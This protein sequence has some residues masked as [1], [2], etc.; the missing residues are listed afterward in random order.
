MKKFQLSKDFVFEAITDHFPTDFKITSLA[1][2]ARL[3]YY[4]AKKKNIQDS[5][6]FMLGSMGQELSMGLGVALGVEHGNKKC[7]VISSDGS[8]ISSIGTL[9][10]IGVV[11]PKKLVIL[12]LDN[13]M[14][15]I[16]GKQI[17]ASSSIDIAEIAK[18][19]HLKSLRVVNQ[20]ELIEAFTKVK[21]SDGPIFIQI[22]INDYETSQQN[23]DEL[24]AVIFRNF[25]KYIGSN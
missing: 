8:L 11:Q 18:T 5:T 20:K 2:N 15:R 25:S 19:C 7:V 14:H 4:Y 3:F 21:Q 10:T 17:T 1:N 13:Q 6:F 9:L 23:I 12:L 22:K 16:T 24:P